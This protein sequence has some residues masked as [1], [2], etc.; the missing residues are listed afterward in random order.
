MFD[1]Y[2]RKKIDSLLIYKK[3]SKMENMLDCNLKLSANYLF[4]KAPLQSNNHAGFVSKLISNC[5]FFSKTGSVNI[6]NL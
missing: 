6:L 3:M 2:I 4:T 1:G 5:L